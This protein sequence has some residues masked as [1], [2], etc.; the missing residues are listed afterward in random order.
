MMEKNKLEQAA[1]KYCS[2]ITKEGIILTDEDAIRGFIMGAKW[3]TEQGN[4]IQCEIDWLDGPYP[5]FTEEQQFE[6][7]KGFKPGDKVIVQIRKAE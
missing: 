6:L 2:H 7:C 1:K 3:M 5:D 4:S